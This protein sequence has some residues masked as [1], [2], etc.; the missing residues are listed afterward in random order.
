MNLEEMSI[1]I[2]GSARGIGAATARMAASR[3]AR[4]TVSDL[5]DAEGQSVV[6]EI[7]AA[8]GTATY[9]HCDVTDPEQVA[10]LM[11]TAAERHGGIDVLHNNAGV[12]ETML[13]MD[14]K[15]ENMA[16]E[17]FDRVLGINLRAAFV[18]SKCAL[19]YLK[20]STRGP[21]IVNAGSTGSWAGYPAGLAYG[22]S[23][24]GIALL[25]KNLAVELAPYGIRSNCYCPAATETRMV[26]DYLAAAPDEDAL[27]KTLTATH[28]VRRL[29]APDDV[30]SLVCFLA[31]SE[32]SFI[33]G[34]VWLVDGGALA[35]RG[36][37]D[38]LGME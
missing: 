22:A 36:T 31:S 34:V 29:G 4:V 12:H 24:G 18:A 8:G 35:W 9:V 27:M 25:T 15:L 3:G 1:V 16:I 14:V 5:D 26:T 10:A 17:T 23:K 19:P 20:E 2:T 33:N 7:N 21:S 37:V 28:L 11:A 30:A 6:D 13:T 38:V 32:A